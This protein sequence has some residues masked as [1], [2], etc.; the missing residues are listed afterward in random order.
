MTEPRYLATIRSLPDGELERCE[1]TAPAVAAF[2]RAEANQLDP[3]R[4]GPGT[5]RGLTTAIRSLPE[6]RDRR[7]FGRIGFSPVHATTEEPT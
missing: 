2:L 7:G 3:P 5:A 1:G 4:D 6:H